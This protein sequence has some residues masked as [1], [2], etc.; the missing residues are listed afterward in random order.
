MRVDERPRSRRAAR[1]PWPGRRSGRAPIPTTTRSAS[2]SVPSASSHRTDVRPVAGRDDLGDLRPRPQVDAVL[3]V[4]VGEHRGQLRAEHPEQRQRVAH[5]HGHLAPAARAAA[6]TSSPIHPPPTTTTGFPAVSSA[7]SA[8]AVV[9]GAQVVRPRRGPRRARRGGGAGAGREQSLSQPVRVAEPSTTSCAP[10]SSAVDRRAQPQVDVV[11]GV[12]VRRVHER[13]VALV[14]AL[15]VSL[16]QRRPL[17]R[18][19]GLGA[20]QDD[21]AVVSPLTQPLDGLRARQP[22]THD[23]DLTTHVTPLPSSDRR[24][25]AH[26]VGGLGAM[27]CGVAKSTHVDGLAARAG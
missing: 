12:P 4:Q 14:A 6:A 17:V 24:R 23:H 16:R 11:R 10:R 1:P 8:V 21:P 27:G 9:E 26:Q 15:Q 2:T 5:Q 13:A 25:Q 7:R 22:G 19:L 20:E 3:P 18:P